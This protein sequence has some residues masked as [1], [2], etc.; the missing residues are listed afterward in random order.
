MPP[1]S[2]A[3]C[4]RRGAARP[5]SGG[6]APCE[7]NHRKWLYPCGSGRAP[8]AGCSVTARPSRAA[9]MRVSGTSSC[10][11]A[12]GGGRARADGPRTAARS[13]RRRSALR[14]RVRPRAS[15]HAR[16]SGSIGSAA[17]SMVAP[18]PLASAIWCSGVGQAVTQ[19]HA[20]ASRRDSARQ[21][22]ADPHAWLRVADNASMQSSSSVVGPSRQPS[23]RIAGDRRLRVTLAARQRPRRCCRSRTSHR[24]AGRRRASAPAAA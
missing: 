9:P 24:R 23:G 7:M 5:A 3:A 4:L 8:P 13:R 21:Q 20:R 10:R 22:H 1:P 18:T 11:A 15:N 12:A 2:A 16:A 19:I 14:R 6:R 17:A